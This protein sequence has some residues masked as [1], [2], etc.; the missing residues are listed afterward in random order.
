MYKTSQTSHSLEK[1]TNKLGAKS[2]VH[3]A[4]RQLNLCCRTWHSFNLF[5]TSA[6]GAT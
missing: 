2:V 6:N 3:M 1:K 4:P 5:N